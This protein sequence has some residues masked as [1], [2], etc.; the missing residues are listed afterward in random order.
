M[1]ELEKVID[2]QI[3]NVLPIKSQINNDVI[4]FQIIFSD[5]T[6]LNIALVEDGKLDYFLK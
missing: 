3:M 1:N 6:E 5:D 2:K 4:R